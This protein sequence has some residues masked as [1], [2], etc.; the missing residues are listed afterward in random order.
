MTPASPV[1]FRWDTPYGR[2][3]IDGAGDTTYEDDT[4]YLLIL[5][6]DGNDTYH[7][8]GGATGLDCPISVLIDVRGN[9]RYIARHAPL[10][11]VTTSHPVTA[12]TATPHQKV[13]ALE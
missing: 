5:D 3:V 7:A 11:P 6:L 4:A 8:G 1:A 13:E 12:Q 10:T 9:D 2:I